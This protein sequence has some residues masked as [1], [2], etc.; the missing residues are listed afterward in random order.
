L[1]CLNCAA[2]CGPAFDAVE[3]SPTD[4]V[5]Q[6]APEWIVRRD[7]RFQ[8]PRTPDNHCACLQADN[9][10]RIYDLRPRCC[11]DFTQG[12]ANCLFARRRSGRSAPF[13]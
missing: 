9:R 13:R 5:R 1:D 7:G 4:P 10:C 12:S 8:V 3:V 11:R 6:R 2:C